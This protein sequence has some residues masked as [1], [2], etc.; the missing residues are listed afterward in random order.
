MKKSPFRG[1]LFSHRSSYRLFHCFVSSDDE[2]ACSVDTRFGRV[3][4]LET[5]LVAFSTELHIVKNAD[6][7]LFF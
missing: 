3:H 1:I 2:C 6:V 7:E 4:E 5:A